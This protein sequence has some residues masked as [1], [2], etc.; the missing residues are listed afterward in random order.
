MLKLITILQDLKNQPR[1]LTDEESLHLDQISD[2]LREAGSD[3]ARWRILQRE[4]L[5]RIN[6]EH[7]GFDDDLLKYMLGI[8][9]AAMN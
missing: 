7:Y 1:R 3:A 4:G 9:R 2:E 6:I 5:D 8:R